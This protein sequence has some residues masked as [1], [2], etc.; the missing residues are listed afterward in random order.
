LRRPDAGVR[1]DVQPALQRARRFRAG[2]RPRLMRR[3]MSG[4]LGSVPGWDA[5]PPATQRRRQNECE[6]N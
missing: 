1:L 4:H 3:S 5:S 6:W 2:P